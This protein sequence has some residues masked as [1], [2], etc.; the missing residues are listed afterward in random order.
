MMRESPVSVSRPVSTVVL[1][2][3]DQHTLDELE[4]VVAATI[5]VLSH[6]LQT[7]EGLAH[8]ATWVVAGA[9]CTEAYLGHELRKFA[10][11][12]RTQSLLAETTAAVRRS[13]HRAIV[14]YAECLEMACD[15]DTVAAAQVAQQWMPQQLQ[16]EWSVGQLTHC[17][18][19]N[20]TDTLRVMT[21][22]ASGQGDQVLIADCNSVLDSLEAK[23]A[24][25]STACDVANCLLRIDTAI[26]G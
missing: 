14:N 12:G 3:P 5:R 2:A 8:G 11:L 26:E 13:M 18:G 25:L 19:W 21:S 15:M 23:L 10:E 22:R 17:Y 24:A 7:G 20:G 16:S 4:C 1:T 6:A 9:G